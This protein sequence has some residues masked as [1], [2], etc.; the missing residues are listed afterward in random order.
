[1]EAD[2]GGT[3]APAA[4]A[5]ATVAATPAGPGLATSTT[6]TREAAKHSARGGRQRRW[7][8]RSTRRPLSGASSPLVSRVAAEAAPACANEPVASCT[9]RTRASGPVPEE[10]RPTSEAST[11]GRAWGVRRIAT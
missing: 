3:V 1:M 2:R 5:S 10:R 11:S 4:A 6:P 9:N 8:K 7:P